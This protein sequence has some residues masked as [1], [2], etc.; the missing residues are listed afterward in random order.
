[1]AD[2]AG[3]VV[4]TN[5]SPTVMARSAFSLLPTFIRRH[6]TALVLAAAVLPASAAPTITKF[7]VSQTA[8][9]GQTV[10]FTVEATG[11]APLSYQWYRGA[12]AIPGATSA[13]YTIP[14]ATAADAGIYAIAVTDVTG[15]TWCR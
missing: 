7:P 12:T 15:T 10:T 1:M 3:W 4:M 2:S 8:N 11:T 13:T 6:V 9:V 5:G 14:A